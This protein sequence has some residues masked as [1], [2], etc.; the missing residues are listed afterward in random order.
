M[1]SRISKPTIPNREEAPRPIAGLLVHRSLSVRL[2][3]LAVLLVGLSACGV[4]PARR[5]ISLHELET[6]PVIQPHATRR[7]I[8]SDPAALRPLYQPLGRRFGL[9]QVC[10]E[11]QWEQLS[12]AAQ[13]MGPCPNLRRGI[14]VGLVSEAG[15]PLDGGWPFR[16]QGIRL[17]DGAGLIEANFNS[18][19]YL[20]DGTTWLETAYVERLRKGLVVSVDGSRY[21]PPDP[22]PLP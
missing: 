17:C 4:S 1:P 12:R 6:A 13:R 16:W 15:T 9:I 21:Y 20:P 19:N 11:D 22:K 10:S 18:G 8:V 2:A 5:T 3:C 14:V 7:H